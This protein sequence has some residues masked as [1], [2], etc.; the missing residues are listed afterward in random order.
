MTCVIIIR[1]LVLD[2]RVNT[3]IRSVSIQYCAQN[4]LCVLVHVHVAYIQDL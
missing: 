3:V 2:F 4:W 1:N